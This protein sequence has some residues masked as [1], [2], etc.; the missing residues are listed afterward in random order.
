MPSRSMTDLA[1]REGGSA[2][3]L[4][5][6]RSYTKA[7]LRCLRAKIAGDLPRIFDPGQQE[8]GAIR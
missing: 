1:A 2:T 4:A 8:P 5:T 7:E 6:Q 3:V